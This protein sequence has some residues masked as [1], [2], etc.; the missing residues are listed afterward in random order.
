M[1]SFYTSELY[2]KISNVF[3]LSPHFLTNHNHPL[4][5][6]I[7]QQY[8][9][10]RKQSEKDLTQMVDMRNLVTSVNKVVRQFNNDNDRALKVK[11]V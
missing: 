5:E 2:P 9:Y 3:N 11:D 4:N 6:Y 8:S 1:W 7:Y 10:E